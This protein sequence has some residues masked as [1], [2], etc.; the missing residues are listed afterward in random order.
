MTAHLRHLNKVKHIKTTRGIVNSTAESPR[1]LNT[2]LDMVLIFAIP[3]SET[4]F[5]C[6]IK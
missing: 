2:S 3:F 1:F 6:L 4:V 5:N